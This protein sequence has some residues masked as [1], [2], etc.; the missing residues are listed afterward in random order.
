MNKLPRRPTNPIQWI[1]IGGAALLLLLFF[2]IPRGPAGEEIEI[3]RVA[4]LAA[5]GEIR[6]IEV[7]GDDL[8]ITTNTGGQLLSRKEPGTS[9]LEML[10]A[11]GIN[12]AASGID[13]SVSAEG[14]SIGTIIFS[15]LPI[16]LFGGL[17][18]FMMRR[19]QGGINQAMMLGRT[20]ARQ[21]SESPGVRF[22]DVAGADEAKQEL[23]EVVEFLQN[24]EKFT[25]LGAKIP[26]G[27]LMVGPP[28]TGKTLI[29]RAVAGE[30]GVP[31]FNTSGS[32]F[33]E[34]FVGV[35]ASRVRDLFNKAKENAP[36]VIFID[37]I[38]A[39][40]RHRGSGIGG[41]HDEREQ[42]LNQILVEMDGFEVNANVIVIAATNRPDILDPA[43]IRPGRFDRRVLIDPPDVRGRK[44]ILAV[45]M[46]G[47]PIEAE[48]DVATIAKETVG[49]TG[50][51][52]ANVV[53]EA[54]IMAARRGKTT[55]GFSEFEEAVDRVVAGPVR[56]SRK[57]SEREKK[58][59]A[60]HEA[61]HALVAAQIPDADPVHKVTIVA[62]GT[63][64]G[65]TRML[66]DE[67]RNLWSKGQFEAM[68]A[69]MMGGHA[70]E[71][72]VFGDITTGA[73]DDLEK[74]TDVA[75]KMVTEFGMSEDLGPRTFSSGHSQMFMGRDFSYGK[76]YSDA[77][78]QKIDT[79]ISRLLGSARAKAKSVIEANRD[80]LQRLAD[81]LQIQE[82]LQ[83]G[84]LQD[85]LTGG[86]EGSAQPAV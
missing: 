24:P 75:R 32:E 49:F 72:V 35:G 13:V 64:G 27:V 42:T 19:S 12:A 22:D 80:R 5:S 62:R 15:F 58:L 25:K 29:S 66:P 60:Y 26:K 2:A 4:Q 74:A 69:V 77:V 68:L 53:N 40:G 33:V 21:V 54:A 78:A 11:Q 55:I 81:K 65:Y 48:L 76:N 34:M 28:G 67:E 3:S 71:E 9:V 1:L 36:A 45:H 30:A 44:A 39:I 14:S 23:M 84:E 70:A 31:F 43:L 20:K 73:S 46:K 57:V 18:F 41:G 47:K 82:T 86:A 51:D 59:V 50:A 52:L 83:G 10:E 63:T 16:V 61:G 37:E 8:I 38:D 7:S 85:L 79:E 56:K 6:S 17:I